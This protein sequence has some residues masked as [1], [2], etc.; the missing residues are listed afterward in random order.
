MHDIEKMRKNVLPD[1]KT[2]SLFSLSQVSQLLHT[3]LSAQTEQ[4]FVTNRSYS[5][6]GFPQTLATVR[7]SG[8]RIHS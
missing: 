8:Y 5:P 7:A 6:S 3:Q 2:S 1:P 4:D